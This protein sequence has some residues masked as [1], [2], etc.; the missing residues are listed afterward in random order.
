MTVMANDPLYHRLLESS[1]RGNLSEAQQAE[2]LAWLAAHPEAQ[3]DWQ[4]EAAL[5][6]SLA[7][8]PDAPLSNNFTARVLQAVERERAAGARSKTRPWWNVRLPWFLRISSAALVLMAALFVHR[9]YQIVERRNLAE[10]LALV[11]NI[12]SLPSPKSLEDFDA[13]RAMNSSPPADEKLLSLL[14]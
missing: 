10:S 13:I 11:A 12:S 4:A 3:A 2:L 9:H 6:E 1:W 8:L 7:G 5:N 14:Q